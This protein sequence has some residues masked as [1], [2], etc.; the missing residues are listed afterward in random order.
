MGRRKWRFL[1]E[2]PLI[3]TKNEGKW[4]RNKDRWKDSVRK[5][6]RN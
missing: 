3:F 5:R 6:E 2:T 1:M 4:E